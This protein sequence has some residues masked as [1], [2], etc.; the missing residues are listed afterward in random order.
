M[1][2]FLLS[3]V[4]GIAESPTYSTVQLKK[5]KEERSEPVREPG[6]VDVYVCI[7]SRAEKV[8][9]VLIRTYMRRVTY[10][11]YD[12]RALRSNVFVL[13]SVVR[14]GIVQVTIEIVGVHSRT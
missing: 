3:N 9:R 8:T 4:D 11:K 10:G 7:R 5:R 2:F 1:G 12:Q 6:S 14:L 13:P